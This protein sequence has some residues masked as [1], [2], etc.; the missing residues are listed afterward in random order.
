MSYIIT[1]LVVKYVA[2]Y[3]FVIPVVVGGVYF[4][5]H[6][7]EVRKKMIVVSFISLAIILVGFLI[8]GRLYYDARPFVADGFDPIVSHIPNN[9]FP[10]GHA[11]LSMLI[12]C[13]MY[14][15]NRRLGW[16][17]FALSLLVS[18]SRVFVGLHHFVDILA[19]TLLAVF[20]IAIAQA[21]IKHFT[22]NHYQ[23]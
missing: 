2:K 8:L 21:I 22:P 6:S 5:T 9:G 23:K 11:S 15:F 16:Y 4:F 7:S 12:A 1:I 10:S 14:L 18:F 3:F 19:G 13:V 17:L 20:S